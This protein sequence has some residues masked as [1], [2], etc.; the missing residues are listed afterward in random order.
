[1][2]CLHEGEEHRPFRRLE[3]DHIA[4]VQGEGGTHTEVTRPV[5][6][7]F[8]SL[9][10]DSPCSLI[11]VFRVGTLLRNCFE[12]LKECSTQCQPQG[13]ACIRL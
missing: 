3:L 2:R 5:S 11:L 7:P 9:S 6:L 1:M 8:L 13:S 4:H 12:A 10:T